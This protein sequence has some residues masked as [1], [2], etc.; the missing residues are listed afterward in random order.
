MQKTVLN[1]LCADRTNSKL[2]TKSLD[3]KKS[4]SSNSGSSDSSQIEEKTIALPKDKKLLVGRLNEDKGA[5]RGAIEQKLKNKEADFVLMISVN[6]DKILIMIGVSDQMKDSLPAGMLIQES[7]KPFGGRGGGHNHLA[8]G[9]IP[10]KKDLDSV[11]A[12][13]EKV[14][15]EKL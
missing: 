11:V 3:A 10:D 12:M 7:L 4:G 5:L 14:I 6:N 13:A 2:K 9:G 1:V 8:Q 15:S